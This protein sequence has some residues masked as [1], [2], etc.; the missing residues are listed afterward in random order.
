[1][2]AKLDQERLKLK[3]FESRIECHNDSRIKKLGYIRATSEG[4]YIKSANDLEVG[5]VLK[6][7]FE[8]GTATTEIRSVDNGK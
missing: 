4:V 5:E 6:L 3:T 2:L 7:H 1:M 8:D